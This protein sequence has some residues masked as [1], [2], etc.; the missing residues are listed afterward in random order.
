MNQVRP[1]TVTVRVKQRPAGPP[2]PVTNSASRCSF[3]PTWTTLAARSS[4]FLVTL[5]TNY[6][7]CHTWVKLF[8][9]WSSTSTIVIL[10]SIILSTILLPS[11]P[12]TK[13]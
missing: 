7:V 5:A 13:V 8:P 12:W 1:Y 11:L 9:T 2:E 4:T 6:S 10:P 3:N